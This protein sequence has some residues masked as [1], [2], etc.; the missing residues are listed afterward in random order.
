MSETAKTFVCSSCQTVYSTPIPFRGE[1]SAP[2]CQRLLCDN[3]WAAGIRQCAIHR[4]PQARL[5]PPFRT[6]SGPSIADQ[7]KLEV[8]KDATEEALGVAMVRAVGRRVT[9]GFH[10]RAPKVESSPDGKFLRTKKKRF[11]RRDVIVEAEYS[12]VAKGV[13]GL[14]EKTLLTAERA[15]AYKN[16]VLKC[17]TS[18]RPT[19]DMIAFAETFSDPK[20]SIYLME[21]HELVHNNPYDRR[22]QSFRKLFISVPPNVPRA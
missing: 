6:G 10:L 12:P 4:T 15:K 9:Q 22:A 18:P 17:F 2:D 3:C 8:E 19:Q 11:L 14:R 5:P 7:A 13:S 21:N 16:Q 20:L 1:C